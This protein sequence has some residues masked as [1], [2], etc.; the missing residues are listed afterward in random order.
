METKDMNQKI[1]CHRFTMAV[2]GEQ[3]KLSDTQIRFYS[4]YGKMKDLWRPEFSKD[5]TA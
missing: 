4:T 2:P 3:Q 5:S 1:S